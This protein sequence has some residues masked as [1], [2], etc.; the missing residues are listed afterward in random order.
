MFVNPSFIADGS[1][2]K[3]EEMLENIKSSFSN[4]VLDID[5]MDGQTK[6][7]TLEKNRR[8]KSLIGFPDWLFEEGE[9]DSYYEGVIVFIYI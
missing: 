1:S 5:W 7:A 2:D 9:L 8:M 6:V 3:V 4:F